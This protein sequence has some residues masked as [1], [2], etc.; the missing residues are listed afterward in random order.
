MR[1]TTKSNIAQ[2]L[3]FLLQKRS[4]KEI[5]I[6]D[7]VDK[8]GY[9]R[10]T[11]YYYFTN[12]SDLVEWALQQRIEQFLSSKDDNV[13]FITG[14]KEILSFMSQNKTLII[15]MNAARNKDLAKYVQRTL[16]AYLGEAIN[17]AYSGKQ[18]D[19]A[20]VRSI[21]KLY[22]YGLYG[23]LEEWILE[24]LPDSELSSMYETISACRD[25]VASHVNFLPD[26]RL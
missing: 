16:G 8:A 25:L 10:K 15:N 9:S 5:T 1:D 21:V 4:L 12:I 23:F 7:I 19:Y 13:D 18:I 3:I 26:N 11:F 14:M 6:Q 17:R 2:A 24:G 20:T 22:I